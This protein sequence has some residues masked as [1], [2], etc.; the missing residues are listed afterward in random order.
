[1]LSSRAL[2][3]MHSPTPAGTCA[4]GPAQVE[5]ALRTALALQAYEDILDP[6]EVR[7]VSA[8]LMSKRQTCGIAVC[9]WQGNVRGKLQA[10][11]AHSQA[12]VLRAAQPAACQDTT[13]HHGPVH[14]HHG[15]S[16]AGVVVPG[17][18]G[19]LRQVLRHLLQGGACSHRPAGASLQGFVEGQEGEDQSGGS[20]W[21]P[22]VKLM[23][24]LACTSAILGPTRLLQGPEEIWR[25]GSL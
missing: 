6:S 1:M 21:A 11:R 15:L 9:A 18:G 23:H 13:P 7:A 2:L 16:K 12:L 22:A 10:T 19:V 25:G 8:P 14:M 24:V 5:A 4:F 3:R 17:A 20:S